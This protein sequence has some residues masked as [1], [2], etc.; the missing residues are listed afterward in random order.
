MYQQIKLIKNNTNF[1]IN[2]IKLRNK[3]I[4]DYTKE[5][6][7]T[8]F[9][10]LSNA[11]KEFVTNLKSIITN[12]LKGNIDKFELKLK[13]TFRNKKTLNIDHKYLT[14]MGPYP[15]SLGRLNINNNRKKNKFLWSDVKKDFFFYIF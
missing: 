9:C 13:N 14:N 11:I 5:Y 3:F 7:Y 2:H 12:F 1:P 15:A 8:P 10:I 6:D 4:H